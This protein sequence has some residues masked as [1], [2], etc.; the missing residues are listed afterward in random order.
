MHPRK[1]TETKQREPLRQS[2][3]ITLKAHGSMPKII[4]R[5][6]G[7]K[8]QQVEGHLAEIIWRS[9]HKGRVY[10]RFSEL[11]QKEFTLEKMPEYDYTTPLLDS[12]DGPDLLGSGRHADKVIPIESGAETLLGNRG[13]C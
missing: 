12:W 9:E 6:V 5:I 3:P 8:S 10:E 2:I 4:S 7:T 11:V 13:R 1:S